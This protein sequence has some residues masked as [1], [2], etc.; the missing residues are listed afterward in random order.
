M[1]EAT[2]EYGKLYI[3]STPIGNLEDMTLRA[4]RVL[5]Q[6]DLVAAEDTRHTGL[7]LQQYEVANQLTSYHDHNKEK[8]TPR[9]ISLLKAGKNVAMVS[10]AGTPGISDP[11]FYLVRAAVR[12]G[13]EVVPVPGPSAFLAALVVSGLPTDRFVFEGYLPQKQSRRLKKLE[14]LKEEERTIIFY[15]SRHRLKQVIEDILETFGDRQ[16]VLARELTKKF[17]EVRRGKTSE[18]FAHISSTSLRGEVVILVAGK[19]GK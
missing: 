8:K 2:S 3:V 1:S 5:S 19:S 6:V 12:E 11:A 15:E 13:I 9:L 14:S 4:L 18:I 7:L 16:T 17:E 10:D